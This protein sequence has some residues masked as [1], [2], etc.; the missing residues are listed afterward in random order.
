MGVL[1]EAMVTLGVDGNTFTAELIDIL[2]AAAEKAA[3]AFGTVMEAEFERIAEQ[4][5]ETFGASLESPMELVA[6]E[7]ATALT[8]ALTAELDTLMDEVGTEAGAALGESLSAAAT[9]AGTEA[10]TA[11]GEAM[12]AAMA[13]A[14]AEAGAAGATAMGES[15]GLF[16][17]VGGKLGDLAKKGLDAAK[18]GFIGLGVAAIDSGLKQ[19]SAMQQATASFQILYNEG[20]GPATQQLQALQAFANSSPFQFSQLE[21][22]A[23]QLAAVGVSAGTSIQV[24]TAFGDA[25]VGTG[26]GAAGIQHATRALQTMAQQGHATA[27]TM[28]ELETGG[29]PSMQAVAAYTGQSMAQVQKSLSKG[30]ISYQQVLGSITSFAGPLGKFQGLLQAHAETLSGLFSTLKDSIATDL[31][32]S[33]APFV[34]EFSSVLQQMTPLVS[35]AVTVIGPAVAG[36]AASIGGALGPAVAGIA[37]IVSPLFAGLGQAVKVLTP[38]IAPLAASLGNVAAAIAPVLPLVAQLIV[39]LAGGIGPIIT[40]LAASFGKI[41]SVLAGALAPILPVITKFLNELGIDLGGLLSDALSALIPLLAPVLQLLGAL[42][43]AVE[44][45]LAPIT[46]LAEAIISAL[47]GGIKA[48]IPT[49]VLLVGLFIKVSESL[50]PVITVL[51]NALLPVLPTLV[52]AFTALVPPLIPLV[53][54]IAQL[55]VTM[56]P[57]IVLIARL[58]GFLV[59]ADAK[60]FA[61]SMG[62]L[63][64]LLGIVAHVLVDV[65]N[66]TADLVGLFT[67]TDWGKIGSDIAGFFNSVVGWFERLPSNILHALSQLGALLVKAFKAGLALLGQAL[68]AG[69]GAVL[70]EFKALPGQVLHALE[71]LGLLLVLAIKLAFEAVFVAIGIAIGTVIYFFTILPGQIVRAAERLGPDLVQWIT[72]AWNAL[73]AFVATAITALVGWFTALPGK[74]MAGINIFVTTLTQWAT[75]AWN[76]AYNA[77]IRLGGNVINF[78]EALPG[79]IIAFLSPLPGKVATFFSDMWNAAGDIVATGITRIVGFVEGL[80]GKLA[81][82]GKDLLSVGGTLIQDLLKGLEAVGDFAAQLGTDIWN[83]FKG[84]V[85]TAVGWINSGIHK[86]PGLGHVNIPFLASG[87]LVTRPTLAMIGEAGDEAVVPLSS[88]GTALSVA[89][90]TGLLGILAQAGVGPGNGGG[91][92]KVVNAPITITTPAQ[93]PAT[94]AATVLANLVRVV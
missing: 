30:Q 21:P 70:G 5:A 91:P 33:F 85:N 84:G 17:T 64:K 55:D 28:R 14:G 48:L 13:S 58:I 4:V 23:A 15:G 74:I 78:F 31:K 45:L 69:L 49:V 53:E 47:A 8:E 19:S 56:A 39:A 44:P 57:L 50:A 59:A 9:E 88:P 79:K 2:D 35:Q 52:N 51:V 27:G 73:G 90:A 3:A 43:Q 62:L 42:L 80:P 11:A 6:E 40:D 7:V 63:A 41:V 65:V 61:F 32:N 76:G 94:V 20:V 10:G 38:A 60:E 26:R 25:A 71:G 66:W 24:L 29:V 36:L 37:A 81:A 86:I 16:S 89:S 34:P 83:A 22:A 72:T 67:K 82:F 92:Q 75:N 46:T 77:T 87:A 12:T 93:D 1:A 18:L 54:A 68:A